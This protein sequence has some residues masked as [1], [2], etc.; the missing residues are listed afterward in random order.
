MD[1]ETFL[2][3][4]KEELKSYLDKDN[5]NCAVNVRKVLKNNDIEL[6]ALTIVDVECETSPTIYLNRY[7]D[8]FLEGRTIENISGE[9]Y[10]LLK[11]NSD[12]ICIDV[13][14]FTDFSK[15]KHC[16]AFKVINAQKNRKLLKRIPHVRR[17]DLAIIFYCIIKCNS[18][19][20][21]TT[22]IYNQHMDLWR[23]KTED[24]YQEAVKNTPLLLPFEIKSMSD[25]I[26]EMLGEV[27]Q[28]M[29]VHEECRYGGEEID[30]FTDKLM[31]EL[32]SDDDT[33]Q[34]YVLTNRYRLNGA[35][36][37]F[38]EKV[39]KNFADE[40]NRDL[41]ILPSSIH[42]VILIPMDEDMR[43]EDFKFMIGEVNSEEVD[44]AEVL[45]DHAYIYRRSKDQLRM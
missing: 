11:Q 42:E 18:H 23:V 37:M 45:S 14:E 27:N 43:P 8:E 28:D 20:N 15:I 17:V 2:A 41:I 19:E 26:K 29:E 31:E 25:I 4:V 32:I 44:P 39:L 34:M 5:K 1:Y 38:Y 13:N 9:I 22:L 10:E 33:P 30:A 16:I 24:I 3:L 40:Q 35:A 12:K 21:A 36:C 6:D 7:Y